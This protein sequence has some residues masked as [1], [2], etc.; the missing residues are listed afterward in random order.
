[1]MSLND[2]KL[3]RQ[4]VWIN[5]QWA[6]ARSGDTIPVTNPADGSTLGSVPSVSEAEVREVIAAADMALP[7][8]RRLTAKDRSETLFRWYRLMICLLYTSPSPRDS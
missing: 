3:L 5:G 8:W 6:D 2:K 7:A 1:M 4:Q